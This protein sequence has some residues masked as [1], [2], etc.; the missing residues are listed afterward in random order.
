MKRTLLLMVVLM[1]TC[2]TFANEWQQPVYSGSFL[3]IVTDETV[4]VYNTEAKMFLTEGND[5]GTHAT[6]GLTALKCTIKKHV[7]GEDEW[8]GK[9]Y[10]ILVASVKNNNTD[11]LFI[12]DGGNVYV[13]CKSRGNS[14]FYFT[15]L[16]NNTFQ[17]SAADGNADWNPANYEGYLVGNYVEY[18]NT[19]DNEFTGTGVVYDD[20][21]EMTNK[22]LTTW[23]LVSEEDYESYQENVAQYEAAMSLKAAIEKAEAEGMKT[24]LE[25]EKA[26]YANTSS[27]R[28]ELLDAVQSVESKLLKYYE[29]IVTPDNPKEVFKDECNSIENWE[30]EINASTWNTQS[31]IDGSWTGF[32][33]TTLNIWS[34]SLNGK[35]YQALVDL[36]NGIYVVSIA[37]YSEKMDSYVFANLN[38]KSVGAGAA[39]ATYEITTNV[40]DGILTFGVG[41]EKEGTNW[42]A[43]DNVIIKYY[44]SGTDALKYWLNS[45]KESATDFSEVPVQQ[46]LVEEYHQVMEEVK[47]AETEEAILTVIPKMEDINNRIS[48]NIAAYNELLDVIDQA[49]ELVNDPNLN[50]LYG[51]KLSDA[52]G[53][54][55]EIVK[56]HTLSTEDVQTA[57]QELKDL[58]D[59]AQNFI[60]QMEKLQSE[61]ET[62]ATI[63]EENK[64]K[65]TEAAIDG[66]NAFTQKYETL[67]KS[68]L[69]TNDVE[70]LLEE[71]WD[72]EFK[73]TVPKE[74]ASD[75]NPVDYTA[76]VQYPSFDDGATGWIND[77]WTTYG[78]NDWNGFADG[79]VID[80][81]YLNLWK[82]GNARVY[83]TIKNLPAGT[84]VVEFGA[85]ADAEG[86]QVYAG[87]NA[88][89]VKVGQNEE[90]T[91]HLYGETEETV[92]GSIW[93]GNLYQVVT[94]VGDDGILEIGARNVGG[95]TV[96]AMVD[97]VKLTY[98]GTASAKVPTTGIAKV[99]DVQNAKVTAIYTLSGTKVN[100]LQKGINL[101]KYSNGTIKKVLF[102]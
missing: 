47:A 71:L 77:G 89:N 6:V 57:T 53:E 29:S 74:A 65:C 28:D 8:D 48:L 42:L 99:N 26:V 78:L 66:Y 76:K 58:A 52:T 23:A 92:E 73:L 93:Y 33:G 67:D 27:T 41:Q 97:N 32:E 9:T 35:A 19:R 55:D 15:A 2:G 102:K 88:M 51:D 36:P 54:K 13:D 22:L 20:P 101:V 94:K 14:L 60:W 84:Y 70:A 81:Y 30:N 50:T 40:T 24:G 90:G 80:T 39:G 61:V 37:V 75:D 10:A 49:D 7:V 87:E 79:R 4:Y 83:Q 1:A 64:E 43:V 86:F 72:V 62:A 98:Y 34:A 69:T 17:I 3:P 46:T 82:E 45:L 95:G 68:K 12:T 21:V 38:Q 56:A 44:G 11:S 100:A 59:E 5:W 18:V 85:F 63:Y 16:G 96:W 91:G 31:W 25:D